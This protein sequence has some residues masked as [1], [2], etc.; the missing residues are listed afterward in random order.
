MIETSYNGLRG[1]VNDGDIA[2]IGGRTNWVGKIIQ[3]MTGS[4]WYHVGI[5]FWYHGALLY[6]EAY[7]PHRRNINLSA[8]RHST[9]GLIHTNLSEDKFNRLMDYTTKGLGSVSYGY[10]DLI[11]IWLRERVGVDLG[12][13]KGQVCSEFVSKA[14]AEVGVLPRPMSVSPKQLE[15][16][17][18]E[19]GYRVTV[20]SG[21]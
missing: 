12:D 21:E 13:P 5:C 14:M 17:L 1:V 20:R 9:I 16:H 15:R 11:T 3:R 6:I 7:P 4:E 18:A 10:K 19:A 2:L 8:Y